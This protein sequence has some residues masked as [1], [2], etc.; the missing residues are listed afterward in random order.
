MGGAIV[1]VAYAAYIIWLGP[2]ESDAFGF[3]HAWTGGLYDVPWLERGAYVYSPA[4]A[5]LIAPLTA[6]PWEAFWL[7]WLGV[8]LG[9]LLLIAG[10]A[11]SGLI[12]LLPWPSIDGYPNAVAATIANGNP[13]L[14]LA[15]A[16]VA[17]LRWP[18]A[19]ALPILTKLTPGIG[20]A[21][22][23]ARGEWRRLGLALAVTLGVV[24][25]SA[26]IGPGLWVDWFGLLGD[27]T[28]ADTLAKEPIL[29]LPLLARLPFAVAF[30]AW[31]ART[32][33]YWAVPIGAMLALPAIQLG[34]FAIAVAALP[35]LGLPLVPRWAL[36]SAP[37]TEQSSQDD[38]AGRDSQA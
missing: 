11:W 32:D 17:G 38:S 35:F 10:P 21:W 2:W 18:G 23:A 25:A 36:L 28:A 16:M 14:L 29:P 20:L 30:I 1:V 6:L 5:H 27:S 19:W 12:L 33:R 3:W 24:V 15:L 31:G 34:G 8:Q 37:S 9:A 13:Q 26:L 7:I 4:F 22:F